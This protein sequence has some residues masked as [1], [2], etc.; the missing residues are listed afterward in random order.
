MANL[1]L[2]IV[3]GKVDCRPYVAAEAEGLVRWR[4]LFPI[5]CLHKVFRWR[6]ESRS[7]LVEWRTLL[8]FSKLG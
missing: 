8:A 6:H 2:I 1:E 3:P 5:E 7:M 4:S